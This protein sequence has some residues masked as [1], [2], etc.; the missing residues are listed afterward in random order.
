MTPAEERY[1][2]YVEEQRTLTATI[3]DALSTIV[4]ALET[5]ER[6]AVQQKKLQSEI[7]IQ[8]LE[9]SPADVRRQVLDAIA[10]RLENRDT[11]GLT[12]WSCRLAA[13]GGNLE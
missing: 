2:Q 9:Y 1:N 7:G 8:Y 11:T 13:Q 3:H 10:R 6:T 5:K 12:D 4:T